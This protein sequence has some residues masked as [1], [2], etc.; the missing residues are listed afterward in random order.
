MPLGHGERGFFRSRRLK[1]L[2]Q[3]CLRGLIGPDRPQ[4]LQ[5]ILRENLILEM[6]EAEE[7]SKRMQARIS[8]RAAMLP[9]VNHRYLS[10]YVDDIQ[11]SLTRAL[12]IEAC[13]F[14]KVLRES[15]RL[16]A[17]HMGM[18]FSSMQASGILSTATATPENLSMTEE[19][20][21]KFMAGG[22]SLIPTHNN[23]A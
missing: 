21:R 14:E 2:I 4:G 7:I 18:L 10:Q 22:K 13:D 12:D 19:E 6:L 16:G 20:R 17:E 9:V 11:K 1:L 5:S 23:G 15:A 8:F 3:A